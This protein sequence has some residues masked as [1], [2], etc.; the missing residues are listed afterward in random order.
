MQ[1]YVAAVLH[2]WDAP[3]RAALCSGSDDVPLAGYKAL[4]AADGYRQLCNTLYPNPR[5]VNLTPMRR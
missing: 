2:G 3:F 4:L 1:W 5:S